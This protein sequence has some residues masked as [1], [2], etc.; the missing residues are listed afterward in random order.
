MTTRLPKTCLAFGSAN[1]SADQRAPG[2]KTPFLASQLAPASAATADLLRFRR[3][4]RFSLNPRATAL[5]FLLALPCL[6]ASAQITN[7][8]AGTNTVSLSDSIPNVGVSLLRVLGALA[9]V[10]AIFLGGVWLFRNWQ[11]LS[12]RRGGAPKL[13]VLEVR[14]LG[15]RHALYVVGYEH[16]RFLLAAS[17]AGVQLVSHL[18]PGDDA[19]PGTAAPQPSFAQALKDTLKG[20]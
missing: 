2:R 6:T 19:P 7:S 9:L 17:P 13:N 11:R 12:I 3:L 16:E 14:S 5:L 20:K 15:G 1:T 8:L 4:E 10:V 18:P